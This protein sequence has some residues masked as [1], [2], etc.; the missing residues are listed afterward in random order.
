MNDMVPESL[1]SIRQTY[2]SD[3]YVL[4]DSTSQE[5]REVVDRIAE[6]RGFRILRREHR[7]GFKVGA[8]NNWIK[9]HDRDYD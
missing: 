1:M 6:G 7:R 5:K 8:I 3:V 2:S 9:K 4:D